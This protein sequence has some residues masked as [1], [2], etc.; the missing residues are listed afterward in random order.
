MEKDPRGVTKLQGWT[1]AAALIAFPVFK[2]FGSA[3]EG[4]AFILGLY[5]LIYGGIWVYKSLRHG[6][7]R[8]RYV[9]EIA[10]VILVYTLVNALVMQSL[11][12]PG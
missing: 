2:P 5:A 7:K 6:R 11:A 9:L 3:G 10:G 4:M 8:W 1:S 12:A